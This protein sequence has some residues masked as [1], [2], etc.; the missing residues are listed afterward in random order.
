MAEQNMH[1]TRRAFVGGAA[2]FGVVSL[3]VP[4]V[5]FADPTSADK[6]A[7]ADAVRV[8][9]D[10]M[11]S[12]LSKA[13]D[14]YYTALEEHD[15]ATQ[16]MDE[17]Q[18][19]IDENNVRIAELQERLGGR[20]RSMYR[21]G[22]TT[23]L[24]ILVGSA[25]FDDFLKNWDSL[26]TLND[27]DAKLVSETKALREDNEAQ[28]AEYSA[29]ADTAKQKMDEAS[30]IKTEAEALVVQYQAEVDS[31]DAEVAALVEQERQAA[32][33]AA[34]AAQAASFRRSAPRSLLIIPIAIL[35]VLLAAALAAATPAAAT[36]AAA[37]P[38]AVAPAA[39]TPAAELVAVALLAAATPAAAAPVAVLPAAARAVAR[40]TQLLWVSLRP[41]LASPT[42][43]AALLPVSAWIAL[44]LPAIATAPR[45]I[46]LDAP[47]ARSIL[48]LVMSSPLERL[49]LAMFSI[50]AAM[51]AYALLLAEAATS[52]LL[53]RVKWSA[54]LPGS[55]S[56]A[57]FA[58]RGAGVCLES[59]DSAKGL[60]VLI[61]CDYF[62]FEIPGSQSRGF[63]VFL[64]GI[65][66]WV[67]SRRTIPKFRITAC[68][69]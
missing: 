11:Q 43:G 35:A 17:A 2:A 41:S 49:S 38:A 66:E 48:P 64:G 27:N 46:A 28:K 51:W 40:R 4:S 31:L 58:G 69:F 59:H 36:P 47:R 24:D 5:A 50:R 56:I 10:D 6:Q 62:A 23:F 18:T 21:N 60:R 33:E 7:E 52:M 54:T 68:G 45:A 8:K 15:V 14:D 65:A 55:S 13:S 3:G 12:K 53:S 19:K 29:Q 63:F 22:Q 32:A 26:E 16:K 42:Y 20:A 25:S 61:V 1:L 44:V 9:L 30:A 57:R 67:S 34:A 39:A 37:T